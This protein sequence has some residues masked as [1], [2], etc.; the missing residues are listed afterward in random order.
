MVGIANF[1]TYVVGTAAIILLPGPNSFF[2]L[3]VGARFGV[4]TGS[5]SS[6]RRRA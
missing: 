3:S 1:W 2:V 5:A 6:W 4:R